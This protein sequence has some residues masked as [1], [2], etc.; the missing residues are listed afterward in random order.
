MILLDTNQDY[1]HNI[2]LFGDTH[3]GSLMK[4]HEGLRQFVQVVLEDHIGRALHLGDIAEAIVVDDKRYRAES[5]DARANVPLLQYNNAI[6]ELAPLAK[7]NKLL[8]ILLGNH[9]WTL[10]KFGDYVKDLVCKNLGVPYGTYSCKLTVKHGDNKMY[11]MFLTHGFGQINS[12]ADDEIRNRANRQLKLKK[13]LYRKAGDCDLM[14]MGHVHKLLSV[15]PTEV[16][17]LTDDGKKVHQNYT[18]PYMKYRDYIPPEARWYAST[19]SFYK[20]YEEGIS[21]YGDRSG[22]DP[23]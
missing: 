5:I 19:G 10:S 14:A 9:D 22:F 3:A 15:K 16:L 2:Y 4:Y 11:K 1:D 20:L 7:N 13:L 12:N 17:Y 18:S 21:G 8:A 6:A 23:T